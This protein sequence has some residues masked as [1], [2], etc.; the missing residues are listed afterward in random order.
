[1]KKIKDFLKN[2]IREPSFLGKKI[3]FLFL[4]LDQ[5]FQEFLIFFHI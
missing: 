2:K 4:K 3:Y 5:I 1:M